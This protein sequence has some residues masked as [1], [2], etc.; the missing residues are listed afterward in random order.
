M[1]AGQ[2]AATAETNR[3]PR[4]VKILVR[5]ARSSAIE[6]PIENNAKEMEDPTLIDDYASTVTS[7]WIC[8]WQAR[9]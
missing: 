3:D 6:P 2:T 5:P 4:A 8:A 9:I 1:T 7:P